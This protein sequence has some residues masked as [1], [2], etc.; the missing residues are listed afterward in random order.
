M[1]KNFLPFLFI[2]FFTVGC[3]TTATFIYPGNQKDLIRISETPK[4]N[5]TVAVVPFEDKRKDMNSSSGA[6][7]FYVPL[8]PF[9][10]VTYQ[11]PELASSFVSISE[12]DFKPSEDLA[13][14]V[15]SSLRRS[16]IFKDAFYTSG[17][18]KGKADLLLCGEVL[19]TEYYGRSFSYCLS[20]ASR[21]F[22]VLGLPS[23][24]SRNELVVKL[25]LKRCSDDKIV[26]EYSFSK[27]ETIFH[28]IYMNR[29]KD[30]KAYSSIMETGMN[31][32]LADLDKLLE[33]QTKRENPAANN[34]TT[35]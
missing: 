12:F 15:L 21:I 26:W 2:A 7:L 24:S 29:G 8:V 31:A 27:E 28:N 13:N 14:A 33:A 3:G 22:W 6:L 25:R 10:Y 35:P 11:R 4:Y 5:Y 18:E 16:N 23:G 19:S 32:A 30:V 34:K 17:A 9:G 1:F 20:S